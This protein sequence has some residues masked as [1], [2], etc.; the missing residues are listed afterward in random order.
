V[1]AAAANANASS[2]SGWYLRRIAAA[3]RRTT[4]SA[5]TPAGAFDRAAVAEAAHF[6][7]TPFGRVAAG[8]E[9]SDEPSPRSGR[10]ER[11]QR[12]SARA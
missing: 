11:A 2:A 9:R 5:G 10:D 8:E 12:A 1:P 6:A 4:L 7:Y 3:A